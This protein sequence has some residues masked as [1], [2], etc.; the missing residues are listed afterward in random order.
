MGERK[1][2]RKEKRRKEEGCLELAA[3]AKGFERKGDRNRLR[4]KGTLHL[5]IFFC[6]YVII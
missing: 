1:K 5:Y 4:F 6:N 3:A 2:E